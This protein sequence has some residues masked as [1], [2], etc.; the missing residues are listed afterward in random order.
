MKILD[1]VVEILIG[2]VSK[3]E[4]KKYQSK[5]DSGQGYGLHNQSVLQPAGPREQIVFQF[6]HDIQN[7]YIPTKKASLQDI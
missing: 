1:G 2:I 3:E 7:D 5:G 6:I 4:I